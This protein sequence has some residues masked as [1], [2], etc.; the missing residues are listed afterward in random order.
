MHGRLDLGHVSGLTAVSGIPAA[1]TVLA[2]L[3]VTGWSLRT[4]SSPDTPRGLAWICAALAPLAVLT[5]LAATLG[6]V[7][8]GF[9][10]P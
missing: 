2:A 3:A 7:V 5:A 6:L 10:G 9:Y 8:P 4:A 1:M